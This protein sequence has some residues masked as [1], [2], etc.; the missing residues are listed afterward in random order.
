MIL[1]K[2]S[3]IESTNIEYKEKVE[4]GKPKSWLKTVSAF[5]NLQLDKLAKYGLA[6]MGWPNG[7]ALPQKLK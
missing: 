5:A 1:K 4:Y 6:Q 7:L 3:K 2:Y